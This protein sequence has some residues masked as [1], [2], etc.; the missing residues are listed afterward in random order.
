MGWLTRIWHRF[1]LGRTAVEIHVGEQERAADGTTASL[2]FY[3][4]DAANEVKPVWVDVVL[5]SRVASDLPAGRI[6]I[7]IE[8]NR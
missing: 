6:R 3:L 4:Q 8:E 5:C 2:A 1:T 7:V